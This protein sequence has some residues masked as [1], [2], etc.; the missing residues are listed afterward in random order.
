MLE[1]RHWA[2]ISPNA[3]VNSGIKKWLLVTFIFVIKVVNKNYVKKEVLHW[4][5]AVTSSTDRVI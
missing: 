4:H 2:T 5:D 1:W 3:L